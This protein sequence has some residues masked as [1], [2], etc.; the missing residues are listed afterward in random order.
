MYHY[1]V[2]E[3]IERSQQVRL[4]L[5]E[6]AKAYRRALE[7][8]PRSAEARLRFGRV[9]ALL[10]RPDE[11]RT[12]FERV[13]A[14][15]ADEAT[16]WL[17]HMFLGRVHEQAGRLEET[18]TSYRRA[19]GLR[20]TQSATIALANALDRSGERDAAVAQL[21]LLATTAEQSTH[22]EDGCDPWLSYNLIDRR[23]VGASL[24]TLVQQACDVPK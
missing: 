9:L 13:I 14:E 22:C 23:R 24:Q 4:S 7:I 6:A 10:G 5:D 17:A 16:R 1:N 20:A 15:G 18:V 21:Q 2:E 8:D 3:R 12:A 11:A 19:L